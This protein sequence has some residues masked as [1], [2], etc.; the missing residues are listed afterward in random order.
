MI[1]VTTDEI[2][3]GYPKLM[4]GVDVIVL[5]IEEKV[6][7]IVKSDSNIFVIG[8]SSNDWNMK[9]FTDYNGKLTLQN[10]DE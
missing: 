1:N 7:T 10:G 4:K 3:K 2:N 6:G 9:T 8:E 5:F